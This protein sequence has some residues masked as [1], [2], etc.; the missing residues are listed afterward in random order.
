MSHPVV[1]KLKLTYATADQISS[2]QLAEL[3]S[4]DVIF[5]DP[6]GRIEGI[7][8]LAGYIGAVYK[9]VVSCRFN[10]L[11]EFVSGNKVSIKW[12]MHLRHSRLA[13]GREIVTRGVTMLEFDQK[14][15]FH[16][17]I[18]DVGAMIYEHVPVLGGPVKWL[19]RRAHNAGTN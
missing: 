15:F 11:D 2:A 9:N 12:D 3:Y 5:V 14:V 8:R 17:D 10:Y 19:K 6:L 18:Y 16:E 1:E 7:D 13:G 4:S